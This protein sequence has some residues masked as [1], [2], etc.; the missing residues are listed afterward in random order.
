MNLK[1]A[2]AAAWKRARDNCL[3]CAFE[4]AP[5]A[6]KAVMAATDYHTCYGDIEAVRAVAKAALDSLD[7]DRQIPA[8][9]AELESY[10]EVK[11]G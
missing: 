1:D 8:V 9:K 4:A 10:L 7:I 6:T 11:H 5:E 3:G 2:C